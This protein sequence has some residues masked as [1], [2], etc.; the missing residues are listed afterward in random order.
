MSI[1]AN[2]FGI[3]RIFRNYFNIFKTKSV[4]KII[5]GT[6]SK[7]T[8]GVYIPW[9]SVIKVL[10]DKSP[11]TLNVFALSSLSLFLYRTYILRPDVIL[12]QSGRHVT[13]I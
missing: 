6:H 1:H 12:Q 7:Q 5:N 9:I 4:M 3:F 8:L 13:S 2:L 11:G 10:R